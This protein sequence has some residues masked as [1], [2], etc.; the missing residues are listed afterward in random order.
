MDLLKPNEAVVVSAP[1]GTLRIWEF[2]PGIVVTEGKGI[3]LDKGAAAFESI[4]HRLVVANGSMRA[5]HDW[6]GLTDYE[7]AARVRLTNMGRTMGR[8]FEGATFLVGS[9]LIAL[10]IQTASILIS[11]ITVSPNRH[12]FETAMRD[13]IR[14][15]QIRDNKPSPGST[16]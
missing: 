4:A 11:G 12:A 5:F 15:R 8:A 2:A 14:M 16:R 13:T 1:E 6:E 7:S 9:K 3:L 10:G